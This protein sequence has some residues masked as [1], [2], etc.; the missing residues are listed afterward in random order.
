VFLAPDGVP[1][2]RE[3]VGQVIRRLK[4]RSRIKRLHP[5]LL[6]HTFAVRYLVSGG[7]LVTLQAMLGHESLEVTQ[8]YLHL[9]AQQ[10]HTRHQAHDPM[11][12]LIL[13]TQRRFGFKRRKVSEATTLAA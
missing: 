13:H 8:I 4:R 1:M 5:H 10:V 6:R 9:S 3:S 12:N 2:T 11:D 7:D